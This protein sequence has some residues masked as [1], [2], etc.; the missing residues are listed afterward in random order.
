VEAQPVTL[1]IN[2][3]TTSG[4]R[5]VSYSFEVAADGNFTNIILKRDGVEPGENGRTRLRLPDPLATGR[6]YHWRARAEDGANSSEYSYPVIFTIYTPI[7]I[8]RPRLLEPSGNISDTTPRFEIENAPR[9]GPVGE[10]Y[11]TVELAEDDAFSRKLAIWTV[12]EQSNRTTLSPGGLPRGQQYFWRA[13][14]SDPTTSGPWSETKAFRLPA[15]IFGPAPAPGSGG[16]SNPN[17]CNSSHGPDIAEC[18]EARYPGYL[19]AGVSLSQRVANM[20]FLR[21]RMIE[22]AK[23]RGLDVGLNLKRGGPSISND[24]VAWRTSGRLEGVDIA[25]SYDDTKKRLNLMWH[26]YGPPNYGH[27]Y[28]KNYGPVSCN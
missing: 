26:T 3:A 6:S 14:A 24:F 1:E 18:I 15:P 13:Q 23:C 19:A 21:N 28:Y 9:S 2:N 22:H 4:V 27:P 16:G 12:H 11:Y 10:I 5:P 8:G 7:V 25:S 17:S 20:Q